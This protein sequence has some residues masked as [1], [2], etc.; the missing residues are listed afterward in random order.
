MVRML[1]TWPSQR[2]V[3]LGLLVLLPFGV[4]AN[5]YGHDFQLDD[6]YTVATNPWVRSLANVPRYFVDPGTYTSVREQADYRPLLQVTYAL[7]YR[8]SGYDMSAWHT[9]QILLHVVVTL[10]LFALCRRLLVLGAGPP[11]DRL[12]FLA[13]AVFA[14]H[15]VNAGVVD[16]INAR[17]SLLTAAFLLP[18]LLA[19]LRPTSDDR[20]RRPQWSA[21]MFFALALFT[22]VEAVGVLGAFWA[23]ELWQRGREEPDVGIV[24]AAWRAFDKRTLRRL[25]PALAITVVY[26]AIRSKVMAPFPFEA[27]RHN[28]DVGAYEYFV[29]QLTAWWH[30]VARWLGPVSL[31]ADNLAYPVYRSW[32]E[33]AVLLAAGGWL[34]VAALLVAAWRRAPWLTFVAVASLA[35]ISPTSSIAPLAEMVNE[36]RPYL[37]VGILSLAVV[38]PAAGALRPW[39]AAPRA[40][41]LASFAVVLVALSALTWQRNRV[42]ATGASYWRDILDKAPSSRA[43]LNFGL[44]RAQAGDYADAMKH[45]RQALAM[46]PNWYYTHGNMA[47]A[48]DAL[49]RPDSARA[50]FDLAVANDAYSGHALMWRGEFHVSQ[51]N[52]AEARDDFLVAQQI[53]LQPYR[54]AKG[55]AAAYAGLADSAQSLRLQARMRE[56]D[57]AAADRDIA[58]LP[59]PDPGGPR[60]HPDHVMSEGLALLRIGDAAAAITRFRGVI[61]MNPTHYGAHYQL[62]VALDRV[63]RSREAR[64]LWE[65]VLRMAEGYRD[66][67]TIR[68]A[69]A[70]LTTP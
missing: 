5:G 42:F 22:K 33:P 28:P 61:Q 60:P 1:R 12:A 43:H 19:Y 49:G 32:R 65:T 40:V 44:S 25:A 27:A 35:L 41:A 67:T 66:S 15:P 69:R 50:H 23:F 11:S 14:V 58:A 57:P 17:S 54:V 20:Y 51:R 10:G 46:A 62:A 53:S 31:V 47:W 4:Y 8:I 7:D 6:T 2:A 29:T 56:L 64:A 63:G 34:A 24:R 68:T 26:F 55:L 48:F 9:T 36:H 21:A 37:P 30:Y 38:I 45:Y 52:F 13:A 18:A 70:R 3:Y 16:Y 59:T 39:S